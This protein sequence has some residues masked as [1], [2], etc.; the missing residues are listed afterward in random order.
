M[1][2]KYLL[3]YLWD[4]PVLGFDCEILPIIL[5]EKSVKVLVWHLLER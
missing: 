5:K 3:F 4:D 2:T 1:N